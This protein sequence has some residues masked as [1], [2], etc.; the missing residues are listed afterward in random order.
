MRCGSR[1]TAT[2]TVSFAVPASIALATIVIAIPLTPNFLALVTIVHMVAISIAIPVIVFSSCVAVL[3]VD[4]A[5]LTFVTA[6]SAGG[7]V[8]GAQGW[9]R[10]HDVAC[11]HGVAPAI[12]ALTSA[13]PA[14]HAAS[15]ARRCSFGCRNLEGDVACTGG[16]GVVWEH[17]TAGEGEQ[18]EVGERA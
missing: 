15:T 2:I 9:C 13:Q 11:R 5:C 14:P 16:T 4:V 18:H 8:S 1:V 6:G 7:G 12:V 3:V 17:K 10:G